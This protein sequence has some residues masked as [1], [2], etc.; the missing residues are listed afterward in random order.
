MK[1]HLMLFVAAL[2]TSVSLAVLIAGPAKAEAIGSWLHN[3]L[4]VKG[5]AYFYSS[6]TASVYLTILGNQSTKPTG[7]VEG[8]VVYD[9]TNHRLYVATKTTTS[10]TD[11]WLGV[12][13]EY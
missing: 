1:K 12:W 3:Q 7:A 8:S 11:G 6:K 2:A 4:I 9:S 5:P 13:T 10:G